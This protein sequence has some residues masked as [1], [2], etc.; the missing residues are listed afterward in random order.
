MMN[1]LRHAFRT[2]I[3]SPGFSA[4]AIATL[5]IA[6]GVNSAIFSIVNGVMLRPVVPLKP[7]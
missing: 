1:D 2:L 6:I 3:K 7:E 5:A 4:V